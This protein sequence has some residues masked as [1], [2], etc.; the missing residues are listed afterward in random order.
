MKLIVAILRA[1][2]LGSVQRALAGRDVSLLSVSQVVSGGRDPRYTEIYRGRQITMR[3]PRL[4]MEI[5]VS[6]RM[7]E[8]VLAA[9]AQAISGDDPESP[10]DG[11]IFVMTLT[12]CIH[13]GNGKREPAPVAG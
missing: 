11:E 13:L 1:E 2:N 5:A 9:V 8:S 10:A 3:Q 4:R 6:E 12:E 7:V